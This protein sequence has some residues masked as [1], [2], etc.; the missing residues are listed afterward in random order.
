MDWFLD[1]ARS[2]GVEHKAPLPLLMGRHLLK[3]GLPPG[4]RIGQILSQV[5]ERQ[6]DGQVSTVDE[7]TQIARKIIDLGTSRES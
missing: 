4:P 1:R 3:L 7:A 6:L 5:Y 2:L